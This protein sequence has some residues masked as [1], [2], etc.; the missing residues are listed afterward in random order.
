MTSLLNGFVNCARLTSAP[1]VEV[2]LVGPNCL[3]YPLTEFTSAKFSPSIH[4]M[5]EFTIRFCE[6]D[7]P[8]ELQQCCTGVEVSLSWPQEKFPSQ[9]IFSGRFNSASGFVNTQEDV[10]EWHGRNLLDV[11]NST[12]IA[13]RSGEPGAFKN[14]IPAATAVYEYL[15]ENLVAPLATRGDGSACATTPVGNVIVIPPDQNIVS[16]SQNWVGSRSFDA[17]LD[18]VAKVGLN[19]NFAVVGEYT[20]DCQIQFSFV[21]S[22]DNTDVLLTE[23]LE[24]VKVTRVNSSCERYNVVHM[25]GAGEGAARAVVT[26]CDET[27][28]NGACRKEFRLSRNQEDNLDSLRIEGEEFLA[29]Q[30]GRDT[31]QFRTSWGCS[32]MPFRDVML[33]DFVRLEYNGEIRT[34]QVT[35]M[36]FMLSASRDQGVNLVEVSAIFKEEIQPL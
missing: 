36:P 17:L 27:V 7:I 31:L 25:L 24:N 11:L 30:D 14:N 5:G 33:G 28:S 16:A 20:D 3:R 22:F 23:C 32:Y 34:Y 10:I 13:Y 2:V 6:S 12:Y 4:G 26:V 18:V 8:Q 21:E 15:V 29:S 35:E 19:N 1:C 9:K